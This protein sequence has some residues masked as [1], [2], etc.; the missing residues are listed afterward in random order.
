MSGFF[1]K[2]FNRITGKK[3]DTA[4]PAAIEAPPEPEAFTERVV[5][6]E[7]E[8][9]PESQPQPERQS[10][11]AAVAPPAEPELEPEPETVAESA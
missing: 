10:A 11:P 2:L 3:E 8:P 7:P 6:P 4:P 9:E 1:K 5:V